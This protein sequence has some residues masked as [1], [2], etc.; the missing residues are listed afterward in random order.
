MKD[1]YKYSSLHE[2][3]IPYNLRIRGYFLYTQSV[4]KYS[5]SCLKGEKA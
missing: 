1:K 4:I 5:V 2:E 3:I